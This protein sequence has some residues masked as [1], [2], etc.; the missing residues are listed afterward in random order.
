M[1]RTLPALLAA[2]MLL[3]LATAEAA[4]KGQREVL[5]VSNN[6]DGTADLVDPR[7]FKRLLEST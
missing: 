3:P 5:V 6:W 7:T 1:R 2:L 4:P